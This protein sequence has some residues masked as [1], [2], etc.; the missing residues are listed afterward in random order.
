MKSRANYKK[1]IK[2]S[3]LRTC[4]SARGICQSG[5]GFERFR[6]Q[7]KKTKAI[8]VRQSK[9]TP[10]SSIWE[11]KAGR[12]I[13]GGTESGGR[14]GKRAIGGDGGKK[15]QHRGTENGGDARGEGP[16]RGGPFD[17]WH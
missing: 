3:E 11:R 14:P 13:W 5:L 15:K 12:R 2:C 7:R 1:K 9:K 8:K 17:T 6:E 10:V 16:K 4:T